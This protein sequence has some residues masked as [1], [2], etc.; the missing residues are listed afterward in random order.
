MRTITFQIAS[1]LAVVGLSLVA[2][3][4]KPFPSSRT[5]LQKSER[6]LP[7]DAENNAPS[8]PKESFLEKLHPAEVTMVRALPASHGPSRVVSLSATGTMC[9][10]GPKLHRLDRLVVPGMFPPIRRFSVAPDGYPIYAAVQIEISIQGKRR[11]TETD[12]W[13]SNGA[14]CYSR[15]AAHRADITSLDVSPDGK[16]LVTAERGP[17]V[18]LWDT[19][20]G[21]EVRQFFHTQSISREEPKREELILGAVFSPDGIAVV[22]WGHTQSLRLWDVNTGKELKRIATGQNLMDRVAFTPNGKSLIECATG[23]RHLVLSDVTTSQRT[24]FPPLSNTNTHLHSIQ[25]FCL[26]PDGK[27]LATAG[28]DGTVRLW[29]VTTREEIERIRV[30][31]ASLTFSPD[32]RYLVAGCKDGSLIFWEWTRRRPGDASGKTIGPYPADVPAAWKALADADGATGQGAVRIMIANPVEAIEALAAGLKRVPSPDKVTIMQL[33]DALGHAEFGKRESAAR[34]LAGFREAIRSELSSA[35][36]S[37]RSAEVRQRC[38]NFISAMEAPNDQ[39]RRRFLRGV[40]VLEAIGSPEAIKVLE[41]LAS[42]AADVIE[43][44][45]ARAALKRVRRQR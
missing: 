17:A 31:A 44:D 28:N 12:I 26:S 13:L 27:L 14:T 8:P 20:T 24:S 2:A 43:T 9:I 11:P 3:Q 23:S 36:E 4:E 6:P 37:H 30:D 40:Q 16:W 39:E 42:G 19:A 33:I 10:C 41:K 21:Q 5:D 32:G 18:R 45:D 25:Q 35:A 34:E 1:A 38:R 7:E 15:F 29:E 22:T